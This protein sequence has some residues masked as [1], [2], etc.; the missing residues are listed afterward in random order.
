[1]GEESV[2]VNLVAEDEYES[3]EEE[4]WWVGTVRVEELR[5]DEEEALEEIDGSEPERE[6][7]YITSIFTRKDDSGL[8]N[9]F[10]YL[11]DA[12]ALSSPGE[13]GEDR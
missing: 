7:R 12:Q 2:G 13:P 8:E 6:D 5:E 11:W 4:E 9:K 10:E 1:M 3:E